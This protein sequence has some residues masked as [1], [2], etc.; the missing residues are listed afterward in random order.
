MYVPPANALSQDSAFA[1]G[2]V[3]NPRRIIFD[4]QNINARKGMDFECTPS[5]R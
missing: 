3:E 2:G 4:L 5:K 1:E